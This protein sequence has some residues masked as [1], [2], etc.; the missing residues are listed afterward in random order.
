VDR[1]RGGERQA[2]IAPLSLKGAKTLPNSAVKAPP[3]YAGQ[4]RKKL[5]RAV[6]S[7]ATRKPWLCA[8]NTP[9]TTTASPRAAQK[10]ATIQSQGF[11]RTSIVALA[12]IGRYSPDDDRRDQKSVAFLQFGQ[13]RFR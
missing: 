7:S 10:A 4:K 11:R 6:A 12:P 9:T 8:P 1:Q 5:S 13:G 3:A 2:E